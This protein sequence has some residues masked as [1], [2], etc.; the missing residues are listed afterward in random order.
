M[1]LFH[2]V[3]PQIFIFCELEYSCF[4]WISATLSTGFTIPI[5][6]SHIVYAAFRI[7]LLSFSQF[8]W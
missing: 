2:N 8:F 4:F 7:K 3:L 5:Y 6:V 1:R